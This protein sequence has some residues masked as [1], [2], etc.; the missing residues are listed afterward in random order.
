LKRQ[1]KCQFDCRNFGL[2]QSV[3]SI[4]AS[5]ALA[6]PSGKPATSAAASY[7]SPASAQQNDTPADSTAKSYG[8]SA[9][10]QQRDRTVGGNT[11]FAIGDLAFIPNEV[12]AVGLDPAS[13]ERA[14]ALG[15]K[16]DLQAIALK[17]SDRIVTRLTVPPRPCR[18]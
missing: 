18:T 2:N 6:Q 13:I 1:R 14:E 5:K 10:A 15:F 12:L 11:S 3:N 8:R 7:E 16:A 4:A 17:A 9:P